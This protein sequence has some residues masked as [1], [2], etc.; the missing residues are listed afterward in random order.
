[1][2]QRS[3]EHADEITVVTSDVTLAERIRDAGA[4]VYPAAKFRDL[5]DPLNAT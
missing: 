5:V 2:C 3:D 4:T 1:M